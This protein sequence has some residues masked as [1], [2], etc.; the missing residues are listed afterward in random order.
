MPLEY[1]FSNICNGEID[2]VGQLVI[3]RLYNFLLYEN[4]VFTFYLLL[5]LFAFTFY[6]NTV[7]LNFCF[8]SC[9]RD[10]DLNYPQ[11]TTNYNTGEIIK[12]N[13]FQMLT[14]ISE[15]L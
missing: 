1:E 12:I 3:L 10:R 7:V 14:R 11:T 9:W 13:C 15:D 8:L 2:Q 4:F 5:L 6:F